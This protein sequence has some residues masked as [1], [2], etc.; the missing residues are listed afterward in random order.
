MYHA[1]GSPL[2]DPREDPDRH[3]VWKTWRA[4]HDSRR[5]EETR[6]IEEK[7]LGTF[8]GYRYN[9]HKGRRSKDGDGGWK[10]GGTS[11]FLLKEREPRIG[12]AV[13]SLPYFSEFHCPARRPGNNAASSTIREGFST[14]RAP[15]LWR[16]YLLPL[17]DWPTISSD[18]FS[19]SSL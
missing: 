5:R 8:R 15:Y 11:V 18:G 14:L 9:C 3:C 6:T 2:I 16:K 7:K 10:Y 13:R 12:H 19:I 4:D 1:S 17:E